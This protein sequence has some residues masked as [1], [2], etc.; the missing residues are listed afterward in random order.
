MLQV[1]F[2]DRWQPHI[3]SI[4]LHSEGDQRVAERR[5]GQ[6]QS[7]PIGL[8]SCIS[9]LSIFNPTLQLAFLYKNPQPRATAHYPR[10]SPHL[11]KE[12]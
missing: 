5:K 10:S 6:V 12:D 9:S 4:S 7:C 1:S 3:G 8:I 2:Q 11:Y